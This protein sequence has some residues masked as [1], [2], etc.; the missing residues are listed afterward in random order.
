MDDFNIGSSISVNG[1]CLTVVKKEENTF[2]VDTIEET[3]KK[4][5]LGFLFTE[6]K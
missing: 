3:L 5:N 4:T 2:S 1:C 6:V